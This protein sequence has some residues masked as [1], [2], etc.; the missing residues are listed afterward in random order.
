MVFNGFRVVYK[1]RAKKKRSVAAVAALG[2]TKGPSLVAFLV[3]PNSGPS[4][5]AVF[6]EF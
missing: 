3:S 6:L 1:A 4:I 2:L 5:A